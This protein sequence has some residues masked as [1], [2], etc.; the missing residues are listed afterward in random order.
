MMQGLDE[1]HAMIWHREQVF[2]KVKG[3]HP[4]F[5]GRVSEE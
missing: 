2:E 5:C 3:G 4:R 1:R